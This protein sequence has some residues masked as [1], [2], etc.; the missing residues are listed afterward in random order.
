MFPEKLS[1]QIIEQSPE[2]ILYVDQDGVIR[3]WNRGAERIFGFSAEQ[4]VGQSLDIIIP[5]KLRER[6]WDGYFKVMASGR[7]SYGSELLAV[8]A[9]HRDGQVLSVEFSIVMIKNEQGEV[10]GIASLMRD[11][12]ARHQREKQLRQRIAELES[13]PA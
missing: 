9:L 1:Q 4:A 3:Y 8:P 13:R 10:S 5:V 12:S 6:H 7:S 11:V 2:A